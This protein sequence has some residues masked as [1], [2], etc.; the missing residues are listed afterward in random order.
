M[1]PTPPVCQHCDEALQLV[2]T[3]RSCDGAGERDC[4]LCQ[5]HGSTYRC[6]NRKCP[7]AEV[8]ASRLTSTALGYESERA[9][10]RRTEVGHRFEAGRCVHCD[11]L[12]SLAGRF[13]WACRA[14]E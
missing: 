10:L 13:G 7:G 12:E 11:K 4:W 5:G 9:P 2:D 6:A 1:S 14:P 8:E 3:C